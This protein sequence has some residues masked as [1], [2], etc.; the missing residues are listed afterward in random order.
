MA[1]HYAHGIQPIQKHEMI[2]AHAPISSLWGQWNNDWLQ[3]IGVVAVVDTRYRFVGILRPH[4]ILHRLL[5]QGTSVYHLWPYTHVVESSWAERLDHFDEIPAGDLMRDSGV[6]VSNPP[7]DWV[8]SIDLFTQHRTP[9]VWIATEDSV[10]YGKITWESI[11]L[12]MA[13]Q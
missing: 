8:P 1:M 11:S 7:D 12:H 9:V 5:E 10:L 2:F 3:R 13:S 6:L 4:D